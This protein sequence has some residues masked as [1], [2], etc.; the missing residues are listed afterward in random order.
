[1]TKTAFKALQYTQ[2]D[3]IFYSQNMERKRMEQERKHVLHHE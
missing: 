1:V 3:E 2:K